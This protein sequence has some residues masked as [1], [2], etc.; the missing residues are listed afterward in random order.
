MEIVVAKREQMLYAVAIGASL[1]YNVPLAARPASS[2]TRVG[3][4][5]MDGETDFGLAPGQKFGPTAPAHPA[6]K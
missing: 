6:T 2:A 5:A 1:A 3:R 4:I